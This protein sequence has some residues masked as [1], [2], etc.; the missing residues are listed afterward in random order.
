[1][2]EYRDRRSANPDA[3]IFDSEYE[4]VPFHDING[5]GLLYFAAYPIISDIC[6]LRYFAGFSALSTVARCRG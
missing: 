3:A 4:I 2:L 6:S 1:M 5:V